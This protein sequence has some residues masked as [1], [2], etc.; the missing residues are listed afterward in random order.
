MTRELTVVVVVPLGGLLVP[1][2]LVTMA[3]RR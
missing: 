2:A 1:S 3:P